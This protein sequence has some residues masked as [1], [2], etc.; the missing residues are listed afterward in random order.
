MLDFLEPLWC[1]VEVLCWNLEEQDSDTPYCKPCEFE[2]QRIKLHFHC[3]VV[4]PLVH[5]KATTFIGFFINVLALFFDA[6]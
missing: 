5:E 3:Y 1:G 6:E 4:P 2:P